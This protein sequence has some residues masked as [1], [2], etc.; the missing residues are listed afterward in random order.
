MEEATRQVLETGSQG[1]ETRQGPCAT[2]R[3]EVRGPAGLQG[4]LGD[5]TVL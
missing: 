4:F 3:R 1:Q 5:G 2:P